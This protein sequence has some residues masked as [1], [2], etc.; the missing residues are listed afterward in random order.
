MCMLVFCCVSCVKQVLYDKIRE[1]K[2]LYPSRSSKE[3]DHLLRH[4]LLRDPVERLDFFS[5]IRHHPFFSPIDWERLERKVWEY[6]VSVC[7]SE[8][9]RV[10]V[11]V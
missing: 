7:L 3:A 5:T 1:G 10:C 4:L 9:E 6:P 8:R 2:L 11:C